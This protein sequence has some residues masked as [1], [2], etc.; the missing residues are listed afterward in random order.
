MPYRQRAGG[1]GEDALIA[2]GIALAR[3]ALSSTR[4]RWPLNASVSDSVSPPRPR[5]PIFPGHVA[6]ILSTSSCARRFQSE[7]A[8]NSSTVSLTPLMRAGALRLRSSQRLSKILMLTPASLHKSKLR[9][10]ISSLRIFLSL[11]NESEWATAKFV[12]I[13]VRAG[14]SSCVKAT[15]A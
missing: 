11:R 12:N 10:N 14:Q 6:L 3:G 13:W 9:H 15:S 4:Y 8:L 5:Y 7:P 2:Q 1:G